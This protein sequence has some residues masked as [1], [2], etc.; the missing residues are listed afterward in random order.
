LDEIVEIVQ[1][2]KLDGIVATNTTINR[3]GLLTK[4]ISRMGSGGISG[5]PL[6]EKSTEIIRYLRSKLGDSIPIIGVGGIMT[7]DDAL[8]K[9]EA[10]ADLVQIYTGFIY[11]GPGLVKKINQQILKSSVK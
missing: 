3:E 7:A 8:A 10:G 9:L 6:T 1:E 5:K 4:E 2:T 11:E